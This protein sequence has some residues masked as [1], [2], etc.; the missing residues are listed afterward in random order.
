MGHSGK[1]FWGQLKERNRLEGTGCE[2][3]RCGLD[4]AGTELKSRLRCI[5][6]RNFVYFWPAGQQLSLNRV[7]DL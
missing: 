2:R 4:S 1:V 7:T 3:V 5:N 6:E